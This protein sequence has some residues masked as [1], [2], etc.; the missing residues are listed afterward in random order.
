MSEVA[1]VIEWPDFYPADL[2][3]PP[4]DAIDTSGLLFRLV[5]QLPPTP[6][7]F[8]STHEE[9]PHRHKKLSGEKLE[10]VYGTSFYSQREYALE[11][12][13]KFP[14]A[15]GHRILASGQMTPQVGKMKQTFWPGHYTVWIRKDMSP[16]NNFSSC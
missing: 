16:H 8:M 5:L 11:T 1:S 2:D 10:C 12:K 15:L 4:S 7:C 13:E 9:S 6:E 3:L 14:D